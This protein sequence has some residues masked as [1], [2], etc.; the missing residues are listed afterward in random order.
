VEKVYD[1]SKYKKRAL[2]LSVKITHK[3]AFLGEII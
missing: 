2:I 3:E 1:I